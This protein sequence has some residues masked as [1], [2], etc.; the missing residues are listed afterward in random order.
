MMRSFDILSCRDKA[1]A[2]IADRATTELSALQ[3][4]LH[5]LQERTAL[6]TNKELPGSKHSVGPYT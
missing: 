2:Y 3:Q 1:V 6:L 4:T 5:D